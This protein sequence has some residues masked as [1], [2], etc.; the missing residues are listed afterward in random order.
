MPFLHL[1]P[2]IKALLELRAQN[3]PPPLN[4]LTPNE[5][6]ETRNFRIKESFVPPEPVARIR[7]LRAAGGE[8]GVPVRL[9][10]PKRNASLP[11]IVYFHGGGWAVGDIDTYDGFCRALANAS[12][13]MVAAVEYRLAPEHKNPAAVCDAF[14]TTQ[15][16]FTHVRKFGGDPGRIAVGGDSSGGN[17]AAV[18]CLKSRDAGRPVPTFQLLICPITDLSTFDRQSYRLYGN[19]FILTRAA[20]EW[21]RDSYLNRPQERRDPYVSPLLAGDLSGLPPAL[22][23]TAE[24]DVLVDEG[25]EYARRLAAAGVSV[26]YSEYR[27]MIHNFFGMAALDRKSNGFAEA[28]TALGEAFQTM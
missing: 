13:C 4:Q 3:M 28:A 16:I 15:W 27:G 2:R 23:I 6:R 21:F 5:I 17:L 22:L 7:N 20:M 18:V 19:D 26:K 9:Y 1:D 10:A 14:E 25:R 8:D 12:G 24:Y 11:V